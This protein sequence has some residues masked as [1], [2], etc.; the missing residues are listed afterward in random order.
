MEETNDAE[1]VEQ[2]TDYDIAKKM[3]QLKQSA[4]HRGIEFNLSFKTLKRLLLTKTCF[5][6]GEKFDNLKN[7]RSIDRVDSSRGYVDDNVVSCTSRINMLK[8][9]LSFEEISALATRIKYHQQK[10]ASKNSRA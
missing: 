6:T 7:K 10:H 8:A 4:D 2:V 3:V 5:Y 9:D 1:I